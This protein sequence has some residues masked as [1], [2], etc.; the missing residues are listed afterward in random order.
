MLKKIFN[1]LKRIIEINKK[2]IMSILPGQLAFF[3][4]LAIPSLV[5][6]VGIIANLLSLSTVDFINL[7]KNTLPSTTSNLIIPV[8]DGS[9]L[10]GSVLFFAIGAIFMVSN[11]AYAIVVTSNNIYNENNNSELKKRLKAFFIVLLLIFLILFIIVV[12]AFGSSILNILKEFAYLE[13]IIDN[14]I[15]LYGI[16]K[17]PLSFF[18]IYFIIKL[19]YTIA[20]DA[21]IKSREVTKGALLTT[22]LWIIVIEGY[23]Y[24]VTNVANYSAFFGNIANLIILLVWF[25]ILSYIFVLGMAINAGVSEDKTKTG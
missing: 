20:P 21:S 9:G 5:A 14:L 22:F 4:I 19:I 13:G 25:Y 7:I 15:F 12:P 10:T 11:G 17:L 8:I 1:L 16:I 18:F 24:Y 23:S 2:P 3:F 6:L